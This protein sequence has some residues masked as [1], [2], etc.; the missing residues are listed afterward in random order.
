MA[1]LVHYCARP[2]PVAQVP[3]SARLD[4]LDVDFSL[5]R[6]GSKS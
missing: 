3:H 4:E 1:Y 5:A 6:R 2:G